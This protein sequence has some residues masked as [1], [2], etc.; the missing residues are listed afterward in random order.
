MRPLIQ[1]RHENQAIAGSPMQIGPARD[2]GIGTGK[3]VWTLP[4]RVSGSVARRCDPDRPGTRL[5]S[6]D[7][8]RWAAFAGASR[9]RDSRAVGR[10]NRRL[11]PVGGRREIQQRRALRGVNADE[12]VI[13]AVGDKCQPASIGRPSQ[14][15]ILAPIE[16]QPLGFA[17]VERRDPNVVILDV[18]DLAAS[19]NHR[20]IAF[21]DFYRCAAVGGHAQIATTGCSGE[22]LGSGARFPSAGQLAS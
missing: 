13:A 11:I 9:I 6:Q 16:E 15:A 19:R 21:V 20:R 12:G 14:V 4:H 5:P 18:G 8:T 2:I 7:R 22:E 1:I 3:R 10:P 17:A